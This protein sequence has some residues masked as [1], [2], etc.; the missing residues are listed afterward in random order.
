MKRPPGKFRRFL[1][2]FWNSVTVVRRFVGNLLF[3]LLVIFFISIIF[4]ESEEDVPADVA[5]I[6]APEGDIVEQK[7]E[8]VMSSVLMGDAAKKETLL[9]DII[10][11]IDFAKD[12][13]RIKMMVLD[14]RKMGRAGINKLQ[15]IG[16][17]LDRF[18]S[19]GKQIIAFGDSF[20]QQQ[21]L[22][23][24]HADRLYLSPMGTI[25]L[26]G[27]G[28]YRKYY[29]TALEKLKIQFHAF[30]VGTYKSA[31]EPFLRDSMSDYAKEANLA[32]L[33]VL[34]GDYKRVVSQQ[35]ELDSQQL[36]DY[37]NNFPAYLAKA[38]GDAAAAALNLGLVDELI[39]RDQLRQEL[40]ER[41]G[42]DKD[43]LT[44]KQVAFDEYLDH[45]RPTLMPDH[46]LK[47]KVGIIVASGI[48]LD[49]EQPTGRIGG[50]T[51]A[52]LLNRA[53]NDERVKAVVLRVDSG[54][55]SA[56]ASEVISR[57]IE[58]IRDSGKPVFV[59]MGSVAASGGYW[60]A[61]QADQIW[62]TPTTI[63][64]SIG[65][66]GAFPTFEKSLQSLG[67]TSDGVGTTKLSDAFDPSRPLNELIA[68]SMNQMIE[69]GYQR[70][71]E[72]VAQ[73]RNME[74]DAVEK[75]AQGRVWAGTTAKDLGLVDQIGNLQD[76]IRA[77]A[78]QAD[79]K[80]YEITY[81][82]Q[83]LTTREQLIKRLNRLIAAIFNF[84]QPGGRQVQKIY[85]TVVD[86]EVGHLLLADDPAG[87]YAFCLNCI[88][89]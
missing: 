2:F 19:G 69:R 76:T 11:V 39:T 71:I 51:I 15:D 33:D 60:I 77:A 67:I 23:A 18:K 89:P 68:Q 82:T 75:V 13:D 81:I 36:D 50:D 8:T 85:D 24:V 26:Q 72:R 62:A 48:I 3:V 37:I 32:W 27:F 54:G 53:R 29:K 80:D 55:G 34:W 58:L 83:P 56:T 31:L 61:A 1:S 17:A 65:I 10:D 44:F 16:A 87:L 84:S 28:L 35:R 45:I 38:D 46:P 79:L 86:S 12:D 21:Y 70:F 88:E 52:D 57:E 73:G 22:L 5:L 59:S 42:P 64:G 40:I 49:G 6:L 7:A 9:T 63:T 20:N 4:F 14:L 78:E 30:R 43:G 41:V 66:F 47:D 25:L 74:P